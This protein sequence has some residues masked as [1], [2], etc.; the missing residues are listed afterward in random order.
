MSD[1]DLRFHHVGL[2][3]RRIADELVALQAFGYHREGEPFVD[4]RQGIRGQFMVGRGPRL[5]VLEP[6]DGSRTLDPWLAKGVKLY[7]QAF[8]VHDLDD[9]LRQRRAAGAI[10]VVPATPATAFGGRRIA[11][12]MLPNR[13]LVELV[14]AGA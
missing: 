2:A 9:Q 13:L 3:S 1:D 7:H 12:V 10:V 5:E 6:T 8:E 14:E 4:E 11:F